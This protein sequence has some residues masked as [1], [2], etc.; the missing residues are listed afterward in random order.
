MTCKNCS[1]EF[2]GNFCNNCG[3]SSIE[4]RISWKYL[5]SSI[6]NDVFQFNHGFLFTAKSLLIKPGQYL[7][8]F[9]LGKRKGIYKPF[10]FLL[11]TATIYL[12]STGLIG[13][14]TFF[15]EFIDGVRQALTDKTNSAANLRILDFLEYNQTIII[16]FTV[17]L[18]SI[19]SILSYRKYQY[20]LPE[21][22]ILN[23]YITGIQLLIY[24][25]FSFFIDQDSELIFIPLILGL[26][27]VLFVYNQFFSE[28]KWLKRNLKLIV[29]FLVYFI[30]VIIAFIVLLI[31]TTAIS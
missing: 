11:I 25:I 28:I 12:V 6:T 18:F 10:A 20:N 19:A 24:S 23:S 14:N 16:L 5:S 26:L 17:P 29:A 21:H 31:I 15:D 1:N 7:K 27:Y 22:L 13:N 3:Q 4:Q 2:E 30:L 9:F 8:D